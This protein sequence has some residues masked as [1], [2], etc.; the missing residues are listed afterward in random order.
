MQVVSAR[1]KSLNAFLMYCCSSAA[2][3]GALTRCLVHIVADWRLVLQG[4]C[5]GG[6]PVWLTKQ[7]CWSA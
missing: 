3:S 6:A 1:A 4:L 7:A 2:A 5:A